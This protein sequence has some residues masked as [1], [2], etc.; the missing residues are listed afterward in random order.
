M[1]AGPPCQ[2]RTRWLAGPASVTSKK[3][4]GLRTLPHPETPSLRARVERRRRKTKGKK[5]E[6]R[7]EPS[8]ARWLRDEIF[9]RHT[10]TTQNAKI[11]QNF[12]WVM[13][14][15]WGEKSPHK[16]PMKGGSPRCARAPTPKSWSRFW[17]PR[18]S[19]NTLR[20]H[21]VDRPRYRSLAHNVRPRSVKGRLHPGSRRKDYLSKT[22]CR[23]PNTLPTRM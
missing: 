2:R 8:S 5:H 9:E 15:R 23:I 7:D 11:G 21:S 3:Y 17:S 14:V 13:V 19:P 10:T 4:I 16:P 22:A 6:G 18:K 1:D 12:V 20:S